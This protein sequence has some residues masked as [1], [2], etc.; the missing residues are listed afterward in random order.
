MHD[1]RRIPA[2][3]RLEKIGQNITIQ[4][5]FDD[6]MIKW[7]TFSNHAPPLPLTHRY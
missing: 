7:P 5:L 2:E 6:V 3:K 1:P 4:Q